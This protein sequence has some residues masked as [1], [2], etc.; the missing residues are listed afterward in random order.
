MNTGLS[1]TTRSFAGLS[2]ATGACSPGY[3]TAGFEGTSD[4]I[5]VVVHVPV[6]VLL[7]GVFYALARNE[8]HGAP[9][10]IHAVVGDA[11]QVVDHQG[12]PHPPLRGSASAFGRVGYE[13]HGLGIEEVHLVVL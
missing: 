8:K 9:A 10:D 3:Q 7:H 2:P 6:E 5:P 1:L 13:V 12:R 11:L 4:A